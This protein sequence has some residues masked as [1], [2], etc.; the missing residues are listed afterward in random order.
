MY[1]VYAQYR[2]SKGFTDYKVAKELGLSRATISAWKHGKYKPKIET[3]LR[4]A[5][6]LN[7]PIE[8]LYT[9][10]LTRKGEI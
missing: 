10:K 6:L 1:Q 2:D 5:N 4:I 7:F 3:L 8:E 9:D